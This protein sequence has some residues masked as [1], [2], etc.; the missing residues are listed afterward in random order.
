M[1][2]ISERTDDDKEISNQRKLITWTL[3]FNPSFVLYPVA[4]K[5]NNKQKWVIIDIIIAL[6]VIHTTWIPVTNHG[7]VARHQSPRLTLFSLDLL[8]Q[9]AGETMSSGRFNRV[10]KLSASNFEKGT[11]LI[12]S[13][14]LGLEYGNEITECERGKARASL[15]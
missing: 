5:T 10:A 13:H 11:R 8:M 9:F 14:Y 7:K 4:K 2:Y 12:C 15:G 3:H 6:I 1:N